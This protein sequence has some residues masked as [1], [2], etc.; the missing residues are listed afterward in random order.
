MA[1]VVIKPYHALPCS[2]ETFTINGMD[3]DESDFGDG[4]DRGSENAED[5]ACGDWT[6]ESRMPSQQILDKYKISLQEYSEIADQLVTELCVGSCGW[7]V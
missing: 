6:F 3:A 4:C 7:C 1:E 5:Y 2:L